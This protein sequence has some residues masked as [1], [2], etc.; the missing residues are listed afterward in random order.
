MMALLQI[1][2]IFFKL[3]LFTIGGGYAIIPLL[4]QE[5]VSAG[6]MTLEETLDMVGISQITPGPLAV[7]AATF[8]GMRT[9]GIAGAAVATLGVI[10]PCVI[11]AT[12]VA[13]F[14]FAFQKK[15][16]VQAVLFGVRPVVVGLIFASGITVAISTLWAGGALRIPELVLMAISLVLLF[17][18][19][20]LSPIALML[21][22]GVFG[23]IFL[24]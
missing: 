1:F 15:P 13:R 21:V 9:Y 2:W 12:I 5:L 22:C 18:V 8:A 17:S 24:R 23:A 3:G 10:L 4:Q 7:N 16:A 20:K 19:K 6:L 11:I 14:F